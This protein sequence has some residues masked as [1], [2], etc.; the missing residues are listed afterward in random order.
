M[1]TEHV[2]AP[3]GITHSGR[4]HPEIEDLARNIAIRDRKTLTRYRGRSFL[5][6]PYADLREVELLKGQG[7]K[8]PNPPIAVWVVSLSTT[9]AARLPLDTQ[10][11]ANDLL[12]RNYNALDLRVPPSKGFGRADG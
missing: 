3:N 1:S 5:R 9:E 2:F 7:W 12:S 6:L 11:K 4:V 8:E 10:E